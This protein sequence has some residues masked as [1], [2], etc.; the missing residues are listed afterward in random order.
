[1]HVDSMHLCMQDGMHRDRGQKIVVMR[2]SHGLSFLKHWEK[3]SQTTFKNY[4]TN[5]YSNVG[6]FLETMPKN[7]A[8]YQS[9]IS[10]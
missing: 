3:I 6:P 2:T 8:S 1:M 10:Y 5:F 4:A 9:S 7:L